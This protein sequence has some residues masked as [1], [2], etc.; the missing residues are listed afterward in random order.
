MDISGVLKDLEEI[1]NSSIIERL[2]DEKI[3]KQAERV[4][5]TGR[6]FAKEFKI[7]HDL[8]EKQRTDLE[9]RRIS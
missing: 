6:A 3:S 1:A 7:F 5:K 8:L 2:G 9:K 4:L